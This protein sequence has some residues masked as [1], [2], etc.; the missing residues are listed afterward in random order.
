MTYF[1][2][3]QL[4]GFDLEKYIAHMLD[5]PKNMGC[6]LLLDHSYSTLSMTHYDE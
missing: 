5:T 4:V 3:L 2:S 1:Y 6:S